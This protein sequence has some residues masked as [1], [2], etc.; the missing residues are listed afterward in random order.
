MN[1]NQQPVIAQPV[2]AQPVMA[3]PQHVMQAPVQPMMVVQ[4]AQPTR[5]N[6]RYPARIR[7]PQCGSDVTT[8]TIVETG[9]GTWVI[10]GAMCIFGL[11]P[12]CLLPFC[13]EGAKDV[14]HQ[15]PQCSAV[16]GEKRLM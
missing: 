14:V 5:A 4:Q 9:T 7:C 6:G 2:I 10:A 13:I 16:V 11:W 12:C 3:A 8:S 15:C 1:P